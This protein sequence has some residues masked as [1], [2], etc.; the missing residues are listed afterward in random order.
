[1]LNSI[2]DRPNL[3]A[4]IVCPVACIFMTLLLVWAATTFG[5]NRLDRALTRMTERPEEV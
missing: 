2:A 3:G 1:M 4:A 5:S